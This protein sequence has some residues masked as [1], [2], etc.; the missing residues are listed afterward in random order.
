MTSA[1]LM[2]AQLSQSTFQLCNVRCLE[3]KRK[4][5]GLNCVLCHSWCHCYDPY[6]ELEI[7]QIRVG[8]FT[9]FYGKIP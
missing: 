2:K 7:K 6:S 4:F 9:S 1:S 5:C 8:A 3:P